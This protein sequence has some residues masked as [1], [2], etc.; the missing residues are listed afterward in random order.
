[1]QIRYGVVTIDVKASA[2]A[3]KNVYQEIVSKWNWSR[4][5]FFL[6]ELNSNSPAHIHMSVM[7]G[8]LYVHNTL[9]QNFPAVAINYIA[10]GK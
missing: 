1:M 5:Y 8:V 6:P 3:S 7:D 2:T 4:M 9:A 10:I